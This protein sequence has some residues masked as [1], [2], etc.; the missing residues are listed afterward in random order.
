METKKNQ[1]TL[2]RIPRGPEAE[3]EDHLLL[4]ENLCSCVR[5]D[6]LQA[7]RNPPRKSAQPSQYLS[8]RWGGF[9]RHVVPFHI[10]AII[11]GLLNKEDGNIN[12]ET[13]L[14]GQRGKGEIT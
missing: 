1:G 4:Q 9:L 7:P 2:D 8:I 11:L 10:F 14:K 13:Y 6:G 3:W 12:C 5:M